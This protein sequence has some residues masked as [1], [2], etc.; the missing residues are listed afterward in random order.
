M[1]VTLCKN[2][3]DAK[4]SRDFYRCLDH[5]GELGEPVLLSFRIAQGIALHG[6]IATQET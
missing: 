2:I 6:I 5:E 4:G 3:V 1:A